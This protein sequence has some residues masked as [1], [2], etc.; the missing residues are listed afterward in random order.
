MGVNKYVGFKTPT[1][2]L[3]SAIYRG[4][5][6]PQL[7]WSILLPIHCRSNCRTLDLDL[8][9]WILQEK[10]GVVGRCLVGGRI[11]LFVG[12]LVGWLVGLVGWFLF[13]WVISWL[14]GLVWLVSLV[15]LICVLI[16]LVGW[17]VG[18][19]R[20]F[21]PPIPRSTSPPKFNKKHRFLFVSDEKMFLKTADMK[22]HTWNG[23]IQLE[24]IKESIAG[25]H[26]PYSKKVPTDPW[27]EHTPDPKRLVFEGNSSFLD[28]GRAPAGMF[29]GSVGGIFLFTYPK[30]PRTSHSLV[31][32]PINQPCFSMLWG[33]AR[34]RWT[35]S[36]LEFGSWSPH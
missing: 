32:F 20:K 31:I 18:G 1:T 23:R 10:R 12:C 25:N 30:I 35:D 34:C 27:M 9:S 3:F 5:T 26:K 33:S 11:G 14:I 21:H 4:P 2:H 19:V 17:F 24:Q 7:V 36:W 15:W 16:A 13:V 6:N 22:K 8:V 28:L 29:Q